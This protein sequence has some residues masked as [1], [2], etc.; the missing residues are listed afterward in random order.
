MAGLEHLLTAAQQLEW[1]RQGLR[2]P[3]SSLQDFLLAGGWVLKWILLAALL[4]WGLIVERYW[5]LWRIYPAEQTLRCAQWRQRGDRRSWPARCIRELLMSELKVSMNAPLPL[6][7]VVVP[8]APLMGLLGTVTG[9]LEVFDALEQ[10]GNVDVRAMSAGV[11]HAMV[12]TLAGLVVS[13]VGLLFYT[14]LAGR[15]ARES[16]RLKDLFRV[17]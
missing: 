7:R 8:M 11:S 9:M 1:L 12:S 10:H 2:A 17:G 14:Q 5:F 16:E 15:V 3:F 13:L 6:I 4:L